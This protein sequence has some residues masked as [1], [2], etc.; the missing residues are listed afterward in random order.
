MLGSLDVSRISSQTHRWTVRELTS[1][2]VLLNTIIGHRVTLLDADIY[3]N[4]NGTL[5]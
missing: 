3:I 5:P 4:L 2:T 1:L